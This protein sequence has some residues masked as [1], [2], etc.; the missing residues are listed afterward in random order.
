[1]RAALK[2]TDP[3]LSVDAVRLVVFRPPLPIAEALVTSLTN[4]LI[5]KFQTVTKGDDDSWYFSTANGSASVILTRD[6]I[7]FSTDVPMDTEVVLSTLAFPIPLVLDAL[8]LPPPY[9]YGIYTQGSFD[10]A[11]TSLDV[12]RDVAPSITALAPTEGII[13][14]GGLR[15]VFDIEGQTFDCKVETLFINPKKFFVSIDANSL[16]RPAENVTALVDDLRAKF[17]SFVSEFVPMVAKVMS[18]DD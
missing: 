12:I 14:G 11:T 3:A 4:R 9:P 17:N 5:S 16:A 18:P 10:A 15:S 6:R 7:Q 13:R 1:M 2:Q 8:Q